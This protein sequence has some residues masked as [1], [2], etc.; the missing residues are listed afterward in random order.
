MANPY[1]EA[2]HIA[3]PY[4][5]LGT[6]IL[7]G[8]NAYERGKTHMQSEMAKQFAMQSHADLYGAQA[9]KARAETQTIDQRRQYQTPEFGTDIAAGMVG[10]SPEVGRQI[11]SGN[12]PQG[13]T[14]Q[15]V[16][17][18]NRGRGAH[19]A[20]LGATGNTDGKHLTD[21]FATLIGLSRADQAI[22]N[23][24]QVGNI[25]QGVAAGRGDNL[26]D[27]L[28]T[29]LKTGV[30]TLTPYGVS[31]VG[32]NT[33]QSANSYA[34]AG[35]HNASRDLTRSK[36]GQP[37]VNPDGSITSANSNIPWKYD[38][39]SDEF[40]APPTP[41][42]PNGRRSGNISKQNAA[43]SL[44]YVVSQFGY[45]LEGNP[46]VDGKTKSVLDS[47]PQGG[48]M[49]SSGYIGKVTD[50]QA[51]KRFDN[52]KEQ[53]STELRTLFRIPGEGA[54][55]DKE[56]AQYGV[57]LP[58]IKND[59]STNKAILNDIQARVKLRQDQ[60]ANPLSPMSPQ[61]PTGKHPSLANVPDAAISTLKANPSL[62]NAFAAKYGKEATDAALGKVK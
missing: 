19:Y 8:A 20:Q 30:Q 52:I 12:I 53:L 25:A 41:E 7:A 4:T 34:S 61:Q 45:D 15:Q 59:K 17:Q 6:K 54:L 60:G 51:V 47:T 56:Q 35:Q 36:I 32:K 50:S 11:A 28:G 29:N 37:T 31:E 43:K 13:I 10:L 21:S 40:V 14:P 55:S 1:A 62:A 16:E 48:F 42:F 57:Q 49:G 2:A 24:S 3:A 33:A 58:D 44:E 9:G 39:G 23:P 38:A 18:F 26:Y 22:A 5:G 27:K 46:V